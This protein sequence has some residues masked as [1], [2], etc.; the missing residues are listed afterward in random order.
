MKYNAVSQK[1]EGTFNVPINAGNGIWEVSF[2]YANDRAGNEYYTIIKADS[3]LYQSFTVAGGF[4]DT[5]KPTIKSIKLDKETVEPGAQIL[6]QVEAEDLGSGVKTIYV[7][8]QKEGG[9]V[10]KTIFLTYNDKTNRYEGTYNVPNDAEDGKWEVFF[11]Y[12]NDKA[13]NEY[14][15]IIKQGN[16]LYQSFN[17]LKDIIPPQL[18][19]VNETNDKN[20]FVTGTAEI[21]SKITVKAGT[22]VL[23]TGIADSEGKFTVII[24]VQKAGEK[25][26]LTATDHAGN[27]SEAKEVIVK[28]VTAPSI[29]T[30][31]GV[32]EKD[33]FVT[34]QA[35]AGSK[36]E[37]KVNGE[38]IGTGNPE[39]N[40][41]FSVNIPV[42]E[43]G[44]E[45]VITATDQEGN[46][47]E[48]AIIRVSNVKVIVSGVENNGVYNTSKTITFN[49]GA[50][51]LN[52][53]EIESG[54]VVKEEGDYTLV[55]TDSS[56]TETNV[57]FII[58]KTAP[59]ITYTLS[60]TELTN[61]YVTLR[62]EFKDNVGIKHVIIPGGKSISGIHAYQTDATENGT[63]SFEVEDLAGNIATET[64][65][66]TN[67]DNE[68][69]ILEK[70]DPIGDNQTVV[71]GKTEPFAKVVAEILYTEIG[72]TVADSNGEFTIPIEKQKIGKM[73][74]VTAKDPAGNFSNSIV[75]TV[76]DKTVPLVEGVEDNGLYNNGVRIKFAD[77]FATLN[78]VEIES[79]TYVNT[80]GE[81]VLKVADQAGNV[82]TI[83]FT[84]DKTPPIVSGIENNGFYNK[85]V[86][87]SFNEGTATLNGNPYT[88]GTIVEEEGSYT[89]EV[90][91]SI[92]NLTNLVFT[93]DKTAPEAPRVHPVTDVTFAVTGEAEPWTDVEIS[94]HGLVL[95]TY[96]TWIDGQY[97]INIP[98]QEEGTELVIT[99]RDRAGNV[100]EATKV[101]VQDVTA[102]GKPDVKDVTDKDIY[103]TGQA[104][105][106]SKIEVK[107]NGSIIG[108]ETADEDGKFK[109]TIPVQKPGTEL[110]ITAIDKAGNV[111]ESSVVVVKDV[112]A[113]EKPVVNEV[114]D[115]DTFVIGKA[116]AGSKVEVKVTGSVIGTGTVGQ[117]GKFKLTIRVQKA[118]TV[119]KI[120]ATDTDGNES[121]E[122][123]IKVIDKTAPTVLTVN[124][125][126]D[127][128]KEVIGKTEPGATV[129]I[130]I[131]TKIYAAKADT[132]GNFKVVIPA[133]K[134]GIKLVVTAKDAAGN[135]SAA[136]S[137]TVIDKTAPVTPT[138][139]AISDQTKVVTG[140]AEA[141]AIVTVM[142]GTK[143]Y[144]AKVDAKGNYK[145]TIPVQKVGT[146]VVVTTKDAA[147][148]VS[149]AKSVIVIDKTAPSAPKIKTTVKS[150]TKE[151]TGTAEA[152]SIITIKV[153]SKVIGTAKADSKGSF[154]VKI[155]AQKKKTVFRV[156]ATDKAKNVSKAATV[157]VK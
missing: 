146:K 45:L 16:E 17:I 149:V 35:E 32:T 15:T 44:T 21:G 67:I 121:E 80:D 156:T 87:I 41:E 26:T 150:T 129:L 154:K 127:K 62:A 116:E 48:A 111:S 122:T 144:I 39:Q 98:L 110:V 133:Q 94:A 22:T 53:I 118:G 88:S 40:G 30:V 125:V 58:D 51:K 19:D 46:V 132:T 112:T 84:V 106:E 27:V 36:V 83:Q 99:A 108:T 42:Q 102:P 130:K 25:L 59:V 76:E 24:P 143:K 136:K 73:I 79:G 105:S 151:V 75:V 96:T 54:Y 101:V 56:S 126:S 14:Y 109:V 3:E 34:G 145:V 2:I 52:G 65:E 140:R 117:D 64:V 91:D 20:N 11:I 63:Y 142:I 5:T 71:T 138:V 90:I 12:A 148:N 49:T 134:A 9:G 103:I 155:K 120:V 97:Y 13:G 74:R 107:V 95:G 23:G 57:H 124:T 69:P 55:V 70:V 10:E 153:G 78:G 104:E 47:S 66:I 38:V 123:T 18:L 89:L 92:G 33:T 135:V 1:Y 82:T 128:S 157:R 137:I 60:T 4:D 68:A 141:G 86:N 37:V 147:G 50:A 7:K 8:L 28:D 113:P 115:K 6:V 29:P 85:G 72:S 139:S 119:L 93:I 131:G 100:S 152:Y 31:N 114:N 81:Y 77:G 61:D 43:A